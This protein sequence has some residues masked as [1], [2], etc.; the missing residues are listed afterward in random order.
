[1]LRTGCFVAVSVLAMLVSAG[2]PGAAAADIVSPA[3]ACTGTATWT[4]GGVAAVSQQLSPDDVITI[5]RQDTV[6]WSGTV[7]GPA[8]G[9]ARTVDGR[10][11]LRLPPPFGSVA[12]ARWSGPTTATD[13]SGTYAYNLP[14]L[15][16]AGVVL[17]LDASHDEGGARHCSA[18]V[19]LIIA[20]GMFDSPVIWLDLVLLLAS[21][22]ALAL[23]GRS[24]AP[25]SAGRVIGG[26][27]V[28]LPF[29]LF[30]G[31]GLVL[32]GV[33]PLASPVV[34]IVLV[35][36]MVLGAA[37]SWWAPLGHRAPA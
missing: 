35:L 29:G 17:G 28:G 26:A 7:L 13:K 32:S 36:G 4:A 14:S 20:G 11:S 16:P 37:W 10:V 9:T 31:L 27:L 33:V 34:T 25:P 2:L 24:T 23:I 19:G 30:A 21:V 5:P 6:S 12:I 8:P 22:A 3:G 18:Q 1:M 15:V